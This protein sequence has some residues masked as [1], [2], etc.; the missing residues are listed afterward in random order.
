MIIIIICTAVVLSAVLL[1]LFLIFPSVKYRFPQEFT[2]KPIVHRGMVNS[3]FPENSFKAIKAAID[4]G[5]PV[6][7]DVRLTKDEIPVVFHDKSLKRMCGEDRLLKD[8][9]YAELSEL[10]LASSN[11][12]IPTLAEVLDGADVKV[13][14]LIELKGEDRSAVAKKVAELLVHYDGIVAVESFN[15]YHLMRFRR[16]DSAVSLGLLSGRKI[17][18]TPFTVFFG[19]LAMSMCLNFLFRPDFIAFRY[20]DKLSLGVKICRKLGT[21]V[22]GWTVV[23]NQAYIENRNRFDGLICDNIVRER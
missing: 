1:Y 23:G 7:F 19:T 16:Y 15:P 5:F 18:S 4:E 12:H 11:E 21:P 13:P 14:L 20:T 10:Y 2:E 6:E 9:C 8:V 3:K 22:F 17:G